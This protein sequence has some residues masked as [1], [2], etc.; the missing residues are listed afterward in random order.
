MTWG[1][2]TDEQIVYV[3]SGVKRAL[4]GKPAI[5]RLKIVELNIPE[6][7]SCA[8]VET[9]YTEEEV[10]NADQGSK[11]IEPEY[12]LLKEFPELYN[13]LGKINVGDPIRIQLKDGT[14]P[15]QTFSPR[16]IPI[17]QIKKVINELQKMIKLGVIR[18][19]LLDLT[20]TFFVFF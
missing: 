19:P 11:K 2:I 15:H 3:C 12:P 17:P 5:R 7:Y 4:L 8:N 14:V 6:S 16:H 20:S 18:G 1:D 9:E 13:G 10:D